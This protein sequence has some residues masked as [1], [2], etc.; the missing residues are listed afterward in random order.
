MRVR[1]TSSTYNVSCHDQRNEAYGATAG[2]YGAKVDVENVGPS[3]RGNGIDL[4]TVPR[5]VTELR[6]DERAVLE[7]EA[8]CGH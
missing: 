5:A 3:R 1:S 2:A 6:E 7:G 8:R 4:C